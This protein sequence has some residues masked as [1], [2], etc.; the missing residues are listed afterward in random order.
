MNNFGANNRKQLDGKFEEQ[1]KNKFENAQFA[2]PAHLWEQI[3]AALDAKPWYKRP[4]FYWTS[5]LVAALLLVVMFWFTLVYDNTNTPSNN[6]IANSDKN[7]IETIQNGI[8]N[9]ENNTESNP[10]QKDNSVATSDT[11]NLNSNSSTSINSDKN[12]TDSNSIDNN[13]TTNTDNNSDVAISVVVNNK[14]KKDKTQKDKNTDLQTDSN[15]DKTITETN[16]DLALVDVKEIDWSKYVPVGNPYFEQEDVFI[17]IDS[18]GEA[19]ANN[20]NSKNPTEDSKK[21]SG[22]ALTFGINHTQGVYRPSFRTDS[23][24]SGLTVIEAYSSNLADTLTQTAI[25]GTYQQTGFDV[26]LAFGKNKRWS[27]NTGLGM[28]KAT[29]SFGS[30]N[31][32]RLDVDLTDTLNLREFPNNQVEVNYEWIQVPIAIGYQF[33]ESRAKKFSGFAQL[34]TAIEFLSNSSY[35]SADP[36]FTYAM[37]TH[38]NTN[39]QVWTQVGINYHIT[40]RLMIWG[41]GTYKSSLSSLINENGVT[42]SS[43]AYGWQ[44][45]TRFTI[46]NSGK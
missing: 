46:F 3:D 19:I 22:I 13:S 27:L 20:Q 40:N 7:K 29:Y 35:T 26:A 11:E 31:Y 2:P 43:Q 39:T 21:S 25:S 38:R 30:T 28:G 8:N 41:G 36:D 44:V 9:R 4:L 23:L 24:H 5:G 6:D 16:T 42:F 1:F 33:G 15:S 34:G 17:K 45:G 32:V 10:I 37:G 12:I 14:P 18:T